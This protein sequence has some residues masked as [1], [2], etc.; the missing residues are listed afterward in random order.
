MCAKYGL[1]APRSKQATPSKLVENDQAKNCWNF[2]IQM[3]K[4]TNRTQ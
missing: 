3:D 4:L 1:E 2:Q